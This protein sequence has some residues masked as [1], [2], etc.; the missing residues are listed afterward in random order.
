MRLLV[1]FFMLLPF[2]V[3]SQN[4]LH[5]LVITKDGKLPIG[6]A[7]IGIAELK[8][9]AVS[10]EKGEFEFKNLPTKKLTIEITAIGFKTLIQTIKLGEPNFV[11]FVL[12]P[13]SHSLEEMIVSGSSTKTLI[14]E[15]PIPIT[16]LSN[17]QWRQGASTNLVDAV[18]KLP[19]M[20]Q[21]TTGSTL[22]KPVI[23]GLAFNRVITLHDGIRQEDNQWGEEHSLHI[24]EYSIDKYEIIRGAGSLLYGS[25]GLGGVISVLSKKPVEEGTVKGNILSNYQTNDG[26][27]GL[28]FNLS[29]N[30]NGFEWTGRVSHKNAGNYKN[31]FDGKVYGSAFR[32]LNANGMV[33]VNRRWGY[34]RLYFSSFH[35][36]VNV[37][38][39]TRDNIGGF[40]KAIA[41]NDSMSIYVPVSNEELNSRQIN[42]SNWQDLINQKIQLNNY[43]GLPNSA[44]IS[45]NIAYSANHRKE[46]AN[47]F[48]TQIPDLYFFLQTIFYDVRYNINEHKGWETTLGS[49]G[50]Y[51]ILNNKGSSALYPNFT[52]LDRGGFVF[53]KKKIKQWNISGGIR[54]DIRTMHIEKLYVDSNNVFQ[55]SP[56]NA[57]EI[58]FG[59]SNKTFSNITGSI[60]AVYT[61][62]NKLL[63]R[64]NIAR[65]FRAPTVPE[66]A[67][68]GE[69]AGTFR[70]ELGNPNQQSE[71]SLQFDIG[72]TYEN[73]SLYIDGNIFS[74]TIQHY[75]Y[76]EKILKAN[77]Q[78][79]IIGTVPVFRYVQGKA[80]LWGIEGLVSYTPPNAKWIS[81][82]Q[83]I[84]LVIARNL[85]ATNDS[86][87]YLPF[88]P[89]PRWI[90][91]VKFTKNKAL[92]Y[93][94]NIYTQIELEYNQAQKNALLLYNTETFT[95]AYGLVNAGFGG[96][97]VNAKKKTIFSIYCTA[98]NILNEV[99]QSH[100]SRL[101]YLDKNMITGR[102]GVYNI[103]SNY[104][105]KIFVPFVLKNN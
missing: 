15:S 64:A 18:A 40:T 29:G 68:N 92:K 13:S 56:V 105:I 62:N 101:K 52:I 66:T 85:S 34:S 17:T 9:G 57:K 51:Q 12:E 49:N 60:G 28:S 83:S 58:R 88:I 38:N 7:S 8:I 69:H 25:D 71:T 74:N 102:S 94:K 48:N 20:S 86:A 6:G 55:T 24:D 97:V 50:M 95:P 35:Q 22:S 41:F 103:G 91:Q 76:T 63:I 30:K 96:D 27:Y 70:Y 42:V 19:G 10:N 26:L 37:I 45:F 11:S 31:V 90:T 78:D 4:I 79:S 43:L 5:G 3:I 77:G 36:K 47:V 67:S 53:T 14:K 72:T 33:G 73:K 93:F 75:S 54:Y 84:S 39:G 65:G 23:R 82:T 44:S 89:P 59:G 61:V 100:Q 81:F 87:K 98:N 99:Y 104:S 2:S 80:R 1:L 21:I 32:E 16:T 46:Y